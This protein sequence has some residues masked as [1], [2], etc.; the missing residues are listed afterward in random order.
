M[1]A[2]RKGKTIRLRPV[3]I[4]EVS[5]WEG[6]VRPLYTRWERRVYRRMVSR[7]LGSD[8]EVTRGTVDMVQSQ[9]RWEGE[10]SSHQL[11]GNR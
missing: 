5:C 9:Q 2:G 4:T 1:E 3:S 6:A 11:T 10:R 8:T 7:F